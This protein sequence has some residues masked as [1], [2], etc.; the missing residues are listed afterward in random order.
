[1]AHP[2]PRPFPTTTL[3]RQFTSAFSVLALELSAG[4]KGRVPPFV[5]LDGPLSLAYGPGRD[6]PEA[7]AGD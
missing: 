2:L 1:M 3:A 5:G 6:P 4:R 7:A